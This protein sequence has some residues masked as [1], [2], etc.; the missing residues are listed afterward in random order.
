MLAQSFHWPCTT[1]DSV[2][3]GHKIGVVRSSVLTD[4]W[5]MLEGCV[6]SE[7][8][9]VCVELKVIVSEVIMPQNHGTNGA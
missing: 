2:S 9:N 6:N 4:K 7:S 3:L 8:R 5:K 1:A